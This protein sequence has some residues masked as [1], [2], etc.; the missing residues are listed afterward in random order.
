MADHLRGRDIRQARIR[1]KVTQTVLAEAL[2][3]HRS[4]LSAI[5]NERSPFD[6]A[7]ERRYL[8]AI[9]ELAATT[10]TA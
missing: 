5:E 1:A 4:L 7:F 2:G 8:A 6:L 9:N 10:A 3:M